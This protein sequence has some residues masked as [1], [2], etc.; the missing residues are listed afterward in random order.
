M[1]IAVLGGGRRE[2]L[3]GFVAMLGFLGFTRPPVLPE[4]DSS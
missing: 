3:K 1:R 2:R 4:P